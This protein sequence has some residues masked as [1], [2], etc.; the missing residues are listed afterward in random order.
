M[1]KKICAQGVFRVPLKKM[2]SEICSSSPNKEKEIGLT[3]DSAVIVA[4][5]FGITVPSI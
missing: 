1:S 3:K 5:I 4:A 2:E